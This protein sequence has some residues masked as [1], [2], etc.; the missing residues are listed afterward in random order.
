MS[1]RDRDADIRA[2]AEDELA[3]AVAEPVAWSSGLVWTPRQSE[4]VV[5][6]TRSK[7]DQYGFTVPLYAAPPQRERE[8]LTDEQIAGLGILSGHAM[9]CDGYPHST[10]W[11]NSDLTSFARAIEQAHGITGGQ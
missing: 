6:V 9:S 11:F 1:D 10:L 2:A 4:Q 8:P 3:A 5:K 7:Q